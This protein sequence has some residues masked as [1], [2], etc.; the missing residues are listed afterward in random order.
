MTYVLIKNK[1]TRNQKSYKH[2]SMNNEFVEECI[3]K[4]IYLME[5]EKIYRDESISLQTLAEK[6]NITHHQL[7]QLLNEKLN[8]NFSDF[9]NTYRVEE[10][11]KL[12]RDPKKAN[13]KI[14]TI[15]FEV[16]YNTKAAFY[17]VF[18]R[19]TNMTPTQYRQKFKKQ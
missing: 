10:A 3:K 13:L 14:I 6:L 11:K 5:V 18:K 1:E 8:R 19:Y 17:N 2:S 9:I 4:L 12:L 16:G 7:S 15:A